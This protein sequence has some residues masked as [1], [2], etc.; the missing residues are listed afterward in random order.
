MELKRSVFVS[1]VATD[2]WEEDLEV[3]GEARMLCETDWFC[4]GLSLL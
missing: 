2:D 1:N 3:G 4:G